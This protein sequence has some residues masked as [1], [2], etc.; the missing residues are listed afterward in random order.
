[1]IRDKVNAAR[2]IT[3]RHLVLQGDRDAFKEHAFNISVNAALSD[4]GDEAS[5]VILAELKQMME[6]HVW[7]AV[8]FQT[9]SK[10]SVTR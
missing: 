1:M 2:A 6:K 7:H 4:R 3:R 5:P 9:S 8:L 10:T